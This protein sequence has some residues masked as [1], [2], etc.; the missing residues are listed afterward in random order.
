MVILGACFLIVPLLGLPSFFVWFQYLRCGPTY[1]S[2]GYGESKF[3]RVGEGM[4]TQEVLNL[5]GQPLERIPQGDGSILWTFSDRDDDTC[6][7][8]M[9]WIYFKDGFVRS[10]VNMHWEE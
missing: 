10:I 8:E 4:T 7:F 6:S 3:L 2:A 9:R 5:L 1:Y